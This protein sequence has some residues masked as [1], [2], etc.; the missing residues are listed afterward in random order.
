MKILHLVMRANQ[1]PTEV[2]VPRPEIPSRMA[3]EPTDVAE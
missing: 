3:Y 2:Q 1:R